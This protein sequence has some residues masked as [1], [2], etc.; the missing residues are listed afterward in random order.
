MPQVPFKF[1]SFGE[2]ENHGLYP[3]LIAYPKKMKLITQQKA[4]DFHAL[5]GNIGGYLVSKNGCVT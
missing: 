1:A 5:I 3:L 2:E 4:I